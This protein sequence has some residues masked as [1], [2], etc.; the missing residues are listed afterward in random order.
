MRLQEQVKKAFCYRKFFWPFTV[1]IN[2]SSNLKIFANSRP[3]ASNFE[4]F[5]RSLEQFFLTVGQN[6]FGN[7]ISFL[8]H[9]PQVSH[10]TYSQI[11][12]L[13]L[14]SNRTGSKRWSIQSKEIAPSVIY[15]VIMNSRGNPSILE[16]GLALRKGK[17]V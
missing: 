7:K 13:F 3:S 2:C 17:F 5:S 4:S 8:L 10:H 16:G 15:C 6:N 9:L 12:E 11:Q 14:P 1:W